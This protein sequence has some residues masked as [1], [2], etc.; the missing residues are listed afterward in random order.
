MTRSVFLILLALALGPVA[1]S[2]EEQASPDLTCKVDGY[3]VIMV[4]SGTIPVPAGSEIDW[5]V[6]F[7]RSEGRHVFDRELVPGGVV[8]LTGALGSSY[9]TPSAE[10]LVAPYTA[11]D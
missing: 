10:C 6:P 2:A 8:V 5:S 1:L 3:D 4:N 7:A 11:S 9:L